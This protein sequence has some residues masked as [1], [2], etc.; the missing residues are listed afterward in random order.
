MCN[1]APNV[2]Q[3]NDLI[4]KGVDWVPCRPSEEERL[5]ATNNFFLTETVVIHFAKGR[6]L[7]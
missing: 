2:C 4:R 7:V 5:C 3:G 1:A 6:A